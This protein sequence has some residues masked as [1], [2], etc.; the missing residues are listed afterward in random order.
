MRSILSILCLSTI[1]WT[2]LW[3]LIVNDGVQSTRLSRIKLR[4]KW[5]VDELDRVVILRGTNAVEKR[6][7]WIPNIKHNDM[8]NS[9]QIRNLRDWGFNVVRV[10]VMWSGVMPERDVINQTYLD[11]MIKIVDSLADNG[12]YVIVDLHQDMLSSRL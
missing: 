3:L 5:F 6:P 2:T 12:I 1:L 7:P 11:E 9:S 10:G 8:T 4:G